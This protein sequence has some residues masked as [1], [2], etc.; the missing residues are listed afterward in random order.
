VMDRLTLVLAG[1]EI[2]ECLFTGIYPM[3]YRGLD[4]DPE[5]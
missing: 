2:P 5:G 4:L 3:A 1:P